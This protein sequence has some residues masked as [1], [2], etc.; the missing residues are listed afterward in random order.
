M[1]KRR[2]GV[3][4]PGILGY[5]FVLFDKSLHFT[6]CV[7]SVSTSN[8]CRCYKHYTFYQSHR[9][10]HRT[11]TLFVAR[12]CTGFHPISNMGPCVRCRGYVVHDLMHQSDHRT[13]QAQHSNTSRFHSYDPPSLADSSLPQELSRVARVLA[14]CL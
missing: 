9:P 3:A 2:G 12:S 7:T 1:L 4:R 14:W 11:R 8:T 6:Q 5:L 10:T 13:L